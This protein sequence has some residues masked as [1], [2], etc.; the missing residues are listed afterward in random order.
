MFNWSTR[1]SKDRRALLAAGCVLAALSGCDDDPVA[2]AD[3]TGVTDAAVDAALDGGGQ[4]DA[5][6]ADDGSATALPCT[7]LFG[8]PNQRTGL[9][10]EQCAPTCA[11][12][13]LTWTP[14]SYTAEFVDSLGA[15]VWESPAADLTSDPYA[16][17][18]PAPVGDDAVCGVVFA[19]DNTAYRL[20]TFPTWDDAVATGAI[21]THSGACGVCSSLQDLS[22]YMRYPD[23]TD[24]VRE[25][26][27]LGFSEGEQATLDCIEDL[28]FTHP[29]AQI[30]AYNTQ[31]TRTFCLSEC[32]AALDEP[33]HLPDGSLNPCVQCD[34]EVSGPVFKAVAGRTRRNS[35]LPNAMCRPCGEVRPFEHRYP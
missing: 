25:C 16:S 11:C 12:D 35:G 32:L 22:V 2:D 8:A 10:A 19:T 1:F 18:L 23:L 17:D 7:V 30:W 31:N 34:E 3:E 13:A 27:L 29:C 28:G 5:F 21:P 26:G 15:F 14:P 33:Y 9:T 20:E 6:D 24:P 4:A